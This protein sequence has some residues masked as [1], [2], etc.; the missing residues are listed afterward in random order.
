MRVAVEAV[1]A[2]LPDDG[3][4]KHIGSTRIQAANSSRGRVKVCR[5]RRDPGDTTTYSSS[6]LTANPQHTI[7]AASR[8][9]MDTNPYQPIR[10]GMVTERGTGPRSTITL[11]AQD[12][13]IPVARAMSAP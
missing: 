7:A 12:A 2:Q 5:E 10:R 13:V 3:A 8:S 11:S 9:A 1:K 6:A 4:P